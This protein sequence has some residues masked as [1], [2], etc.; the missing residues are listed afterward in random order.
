VHAVAL[1]LSAQAGDGANHT[2]LMSASASRR[3]PGASTAIVVVSSSYDATVR[4]PFPP[5]VPAIAAIVVRSSRR[6][7]R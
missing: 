5:P 7:G 6:Y 2:E 3:A 1:V 4:V